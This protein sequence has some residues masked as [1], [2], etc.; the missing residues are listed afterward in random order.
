MKLLSTQKE[1]HFELMRCQQII[2]CIINLTDNFYTKT[3]KFMKT[4]VQ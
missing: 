3:Y 4:T 1:L 2:G